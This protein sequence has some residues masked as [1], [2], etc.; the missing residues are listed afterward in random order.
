MGRRQQGCATK[1]E[2]TPGLHTHK[3]R[4]GARTKSACE[5]GGRP[6]WLCRRCTRFSPLR[7]KG[8]RKK[9][10]VEEHGEQGSTPLPRF[11]RRSK[12][13]LAG[14]VTK[15]ARQEDSRRTQEK[16]EQGSSSSPSFSR[17]SEHPLAGPDTK[18]A[19]QADSRRKG[20]TRL[21]PVATSQQVQQAHT[22]RTRHQR[23]SAR[24]SAPCHASAG[25]ASTHWQDQTPKVLGKWTLDGPKKRANK[26]CPR[27]HTSAGAASTHW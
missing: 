4:A 12:H 27:C 21:A 6:P 18:G 3:A 24:G 20:R 10:W 25:A 14:P 8:S 22:G 7:H 1:S 5:G 16:G 23:Y 13:P 15:G 11:S 2:G 26:A 19:R 9:L 17:R